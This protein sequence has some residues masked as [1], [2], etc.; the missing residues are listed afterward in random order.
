MANEFPK[1]DPLSQLK[2]ALGAALAPGEREILDAGNSHD[3]G[4]RCEGCRQ[5]WRLMGPNGGDDGDYGPF[6]E[7]EVY[8]EGRRIIEK[9]LSDEMRD[10][11]TTKKELAS[12]LPVD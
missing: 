3:Y 7:A 9:A 6:T 8:P 12:R 5:W 4:C 11:E 1:S 2:G 10:R